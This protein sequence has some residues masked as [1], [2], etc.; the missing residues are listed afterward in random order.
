M[1]Y[2]IGY[3]RLSV[4]ALLRLV[5]ALDAT[6]IDVRSNPVSRRQDFS[7][8]A[9]QRVL[10][11]RYDWRGDALGG[12]RQVNPIAIA[13]LAEQSRSRNLVL[14]C[15]E[16]APGDCHRH[17]Q[18]C[19]GHFPRSIHIYQNELVMAQELTAAEDGDRDYAICGTLSGLLIPP[20]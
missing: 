13:L 20:P 19:D 5:N 6:L 15:L 2:S 10:G 12:R 18:I 14:M 1:I 3:Q 16:E 9:L 11:N 4:E 7:R 17:W 8:M